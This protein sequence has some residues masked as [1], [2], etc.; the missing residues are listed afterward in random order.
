MTTTRLTLAGIAFLAAASAYADVKLN[1][2]FS[3]SGYAAGSY[4]AVDPSGAPSSDSFNLDAAKVS[5]LAKFDAVSA[6]FGAYYTQSSNGTDNLTL[7][8]ANVSYTPADGVTITGGRF[9]SWMG[10]EA[11]D[12]I[13]KNQV[14][15]AYINPDGTIM[16]YPAYH[17]GLKI[18]YSTP[19]FTVGAAL[20][21]SL[22]GPSIYRGDGEL[23]HNF[24][25]EVF[26]SF[27][28]AKG[29]TIWTGIGYDSA[30]DFAYQMHSTTIYNVWV[31]Y[32][33]GNATFAGEYLYQ[34]AAEASTGSDGLIL[35][36]YAFTKQLSTA[37]R[38]SGGKLKDTAAGPGLGFT[39]FTVS[40]TYALT[41]HLAIRPEI[42]Y[43]KYKNN[44]PISHDTFFAIQALFKF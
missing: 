18:K 40:P 43:I 30:G 35:L 41:D 5:L 33:V 44:N 26:A 24:G 25:S 34:D 10:Y 16:F 21:D 13:N 17:E 11:F 27:N 12:A 38:V 31:Q 3:L 20:L 7:I 32:V 42:S 1:D 19:D 4:V 14:S 22:N 8:D 23:K 6:D 29:L 15:S 36:D 9:L 2:N 28:A 37:F 39:K